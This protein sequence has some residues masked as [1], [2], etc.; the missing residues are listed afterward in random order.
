[1]ELLEREVLRLSVVVH[2][3]EDNVAENRIPVLHTH[4]H[5]C[6]YIPAFT[7]PYHHTHT[8]TH[9]RTI[10][11]GMLYLFSGAPSLSRSTIPTT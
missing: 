6:I 9:T 8:H 10:G 1:L 11:A 4:T 3:D 7:K 5:T 2:S